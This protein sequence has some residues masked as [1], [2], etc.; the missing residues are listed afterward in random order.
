MKGGRRRVD[1]IR[2]TFTPAPA[3]VAVDVAVPR[4]TRAQ[5][6]DHFRHFPEQG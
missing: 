4:C 2:A 1:A 6:G 5:C 3:K